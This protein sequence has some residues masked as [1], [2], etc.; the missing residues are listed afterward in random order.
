[1]IYRNVNGIINEI[2]KSDFPNDQLYYKKIYENMLKIA[3]R[4]KKGLD[5]LEL[6]GN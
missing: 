5:K 1:M 2:K 3:K 4:T 6:I